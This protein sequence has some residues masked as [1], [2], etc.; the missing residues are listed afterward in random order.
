MQGR[1]GS[2]L[3]YDAMGKGGF[4]MHERVEGWSV[5]A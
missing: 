2:V 3:A 5:E 1:D 4:M